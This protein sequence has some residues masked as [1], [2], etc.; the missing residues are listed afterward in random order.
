MPRLSSLPLVGVA[1]ALV[2]MVQGL[3]LAGQAT[4]PGAGLP[5]LT[6]NQALADGDDSRPTCLDTPT[7]EG[8]PIVTF[9]PRQ[10][11]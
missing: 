11:R 2:L 1:I 5:G 6:T 9:R 7:V 10:D 8:D 4:G 3:I